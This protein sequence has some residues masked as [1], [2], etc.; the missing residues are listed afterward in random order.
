MGL[1]RLLNKGLI[2]SDFDLAPA[3]SRGKAPLDKQK[4]K[5]NNF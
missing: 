5:L 1:E 4:V 2:P 3:F